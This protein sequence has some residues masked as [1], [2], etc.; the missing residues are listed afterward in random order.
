MYM[1]LSSFFF[2]LDKLDKFGEGM[3][4]KLKGSWES[5]GEIWNEC[6]QSCH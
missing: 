2:S 5:D 1:P 4:G 6:V 3:I